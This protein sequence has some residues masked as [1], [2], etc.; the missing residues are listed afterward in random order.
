MLCD[1]LGDYHRAVQ[2]LLTD[3]E[4]WQQYSERSRQWARANVSPAVY[5][6]KCERFL[7]Q[8]LSERT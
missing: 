8:V 2:T 5:R 6:D 7:T 1:A 4:Q 3:P